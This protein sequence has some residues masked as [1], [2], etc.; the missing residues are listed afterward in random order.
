MSHWGEQVPF[1]LL[2]E[3]TQLFCI[4]KDPNS[5]LME[6]LIGFLDGDGYIEIGPQKQNS[7]NPNYQPKS[8]IRSRI[9]LRLHKRD[10]ELL[11]LFKNTLKIGKIDELKTKNQ[12]R[13]IISKTEIVNVIYPFLINNNIEFLVFNRRR[14]FFLLKYII[15]NNIKHW[16]DVDLN[17]IDRL[18][19]KKNKKFEFVDII[20]LPYFNNWLVG[21]TM[22]EGSFHIK[23]KGYAHYSI[24]Q[25]GIEN[26][27]I[28][29]AIH[30]F[31]KG[32]DS[33]DHQI[34]PENSKVYRISFSSKKDL[35]FII[36]FF[37]KN[38]LLGYKKLQYDNW[39]SNIISKMKGSASNVILP[40][41][42]NNN[43]SSL[44]KN[45]L[46]LIYGLLLGNSFILNKNNEIKLII[47]IEGKHMS[48]ITHI[49]KKILSLGYC[50]DKL[51][52]IKTKIVRGGNLNKVMLLH[53]FNNN[54][55]LELFNKWYLDKHN[56]NIPNDIINNFNEESLAYW[57]MTDG[58]ISKNKL[59]V[60]MKN[61]ND[62]ELKIFIQFLENKFN[63]HQI[64]LNNNWL[65]FNSNN[66]K[67]IYN[68]T[69]PYI[70]PSMKFKFLSTGH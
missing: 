37:D 49:H 66:I 48:Y 3:S 43:D 31:I 60:N 69:K 16:E 62:K 52:L 59:F 53:T 47:E 18:F 34:K 42:S 12:Y 11:E 30:Y 4:G 27:Q 7:K 9:V 57:I 1:V 54:N 65:E 45:Y 24:V 14:Q 10:K 29:K 55:Y 28:I 21:F 25:S 50:E 44:N 38:T 36:N 5:K 39:K 15:E 6:I 23:A 51:P 64:H 63:L 35:S 32:P 68:I 33:F 41:V 70:I 19:N 58:K 61:F 8:T 46:Y 13:L 56:K 40:K 22:A 26:S 67:Q 2:I 17:K 20:K